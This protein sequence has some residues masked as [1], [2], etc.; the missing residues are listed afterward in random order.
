V[1]SGLI[2]SMKDPVAD[3]SWSL[4]GGASAA[5]LRSVLGQIVIHLISTSDTA[6]R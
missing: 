4:L 2:V 6:E 1:L 3:I 5:M